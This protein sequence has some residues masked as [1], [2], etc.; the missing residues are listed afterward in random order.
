MVIKLLEQGLES[1]FQIGEV[2]DP[3]GLRTDRAAEVYFDPEG[4]PVHAGALVPG[5][6]VRQA[7]GGFYLKNAEYI[8]ARI[9]PP[10]QWPRKLR[11]WSAL[12]KYAG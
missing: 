10:A 12:V 6:N 7:V 9:V 8:H 5:R 3:T 4:M 2:H 11:R 1:R